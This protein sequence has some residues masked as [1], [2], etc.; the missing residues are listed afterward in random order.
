MTNSETSVTGEERLKTR[1]RSFW[2]YLVLAIVGF[3]IAGLV[4]GLS[5]SLFVVGVFPIWIPLVV[6]V[7]VL[8]AMIYFTWDYFRRVDELDLL[9]NLWAHLVGSYTAAFVFMGWYFLGE[10][11]LSGYP[12]AF[13]VICALLA[14]TF[15]AYGVRKLGLR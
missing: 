2:R 11:G 1:R 3:M 15:I 14:G 6:G 7:L 10:L 9:D 13:G 4:S 12:T 8:V 5:S